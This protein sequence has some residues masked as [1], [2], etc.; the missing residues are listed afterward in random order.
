[1]RWQLP[2]LRGLF[3]SA[4]DI[5]KQH[6]NMV[7]LSVLRRI[8]QKGLEVGPELERRF[9]RLG[10]A[11]PEELPR[12]AIAWRWLAMIRAVSIV[13]RMGGIDLSAS[14]A[15][16]TIMSLLPLAAL[17][18]S[19]AALFGD[20]QIVSDQVTDLLVYYF[21]ASADLVREAVEG[22]INE[23]LII[24]IFA[25]VGLI[26]A[27]NG[28]FLAANRAIHRIF[29]LEPRG[30][31]R[32]TLAQMV[33]ATMVACLFLGSVGLT[34]LHQVALAFGEGFTQGNGPLSTLSAIVLGIVGTALPATFTA[35]TFAIV[36]YRLPNLDIKWRDAAF[37]ALLGIVLFEAAKHLF[38]WFTNLTSQRNAVYGPIAS[39]V[40]MMAWAYI[41]GMIFLY[42]AA[43]TRT[44]GEMRPRILSIPKLGR[45]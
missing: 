33:L 1:M 25:F 31:L 37:G 21:P 24:G 2:S 4:Y 32:L 28:L 41:A 8:L 42:G 38:F 29:E 36:Y 11:P 17:A 19:V 7:K 5:E 26:L 3:K 40:I 39:V 9:S 16:F 43:V 12:S 34:A 45:D 18:L 14:L 15:Y 22:L 27:A 35:A 13:L 6:G 30:A 44:A 20:R 10:T 23:S